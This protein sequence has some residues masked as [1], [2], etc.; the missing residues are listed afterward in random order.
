MVL[1]VFVEGRAQHLVG[2]SG[3]SFSREESGRRT[4]RRYL[5][6]ALGGSRYSRVQKTQ[7]Y[8]DSC[9]HTFW[10]RTVARLA[11][12]E[13]NTAGRAL[14]SAREVGRSPKPQG[15]HKNGGDSE[16]SESPVG[17]NP[18]GYPD[19]CRKG[20]IA[21]PCDS[22]APSSSLVGLLSPLS[23]PGPTSRAA[24][25]PSD[26]SRHA[27]DGPQSFPCSCREFAQCPLCSLSLGRCS[28]PLH[29][30]AE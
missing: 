8:V 4:G 27:V 1:H 12:T 22:E 19:I 29:V 26:V 2:T 10:G 9:R 3:G 16:T 24:S 11:A 21:V 5:G 30:Q 15:A 25:Y 20:A 18:R 17:S 13:R 14:G 6:G 7:S 23:N 28:I